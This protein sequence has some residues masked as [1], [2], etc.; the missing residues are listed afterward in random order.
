[1][2]GSTSGEGAQVR[3]IEPQ[4]FGSPLGYWDMGEQPREDDVLLA[5]ALA[6]GDPS[7]RRLLPDRR[8]GVDRRKETVSVS[9]DRRRGAE[10]RR[11][12]RRKDE[13]SPAGL[14]MRMLRL[15]R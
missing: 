5:L 6:A 8:S 4:L 13:T 10:R 7:E 12:A 2:S 9:P 11:R 14:L 15:G 3:D 1:M